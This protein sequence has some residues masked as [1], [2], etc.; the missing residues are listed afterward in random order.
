MPERVGKDPG[1]GGARLGELP[2]G[3]EAYPPCATTE[4]DLAA[5]VREAL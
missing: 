4:V 2:G 5:A 1:A 3:E